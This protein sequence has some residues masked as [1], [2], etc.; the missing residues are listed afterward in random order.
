[1]RHLVLLCSSALLAG[2]EAAT[3]SLPDYA[4]PV[5]VGTITAEV[6]PESSGLAASRRQ[7]DVLW[8]HNDSGHPPLLHAIGTDGGLRGS[9]VLRGV[10]FQD[11]EDLAAFTL[12]GTPYLLLADIGDNKARYDRYRLHVF[13]EPPVSDLGRPLVGSVTPEWTVT[14]TYPD[15][16]R[17][18]EGVGVDTR[19]GT[20][21][22]ITKRDD[23]PRLYALPLR[24]PPD[25]QD[26]TATFLGTLGGLEAPTEEDLQNRHGD[27]R[28][29]PTGFSISP[30]GERA[31]LATYKHLYL[32]SCPDGDWAAA[33]TAPAAILPRPQ[34][35][36]AESVCFDA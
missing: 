25:G 6:L 30:S 23:P 28:A 7:P 12:D 10:P 24:M 9:V 33:L 2:S 19:S 34:L 26:V 13:E 14:Y 35:K 15:G 16:A 8:T 1:M 27:H 32:Y 18:A 17:D 22:V 21:L 29:Q 31:V 5:T 3:G 4:P 36:Q 20:V 11:P